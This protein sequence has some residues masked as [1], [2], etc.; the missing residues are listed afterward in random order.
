MY[1]IYSVVIPSIMKSPEGLVA[2]LV[3]LEESSCENGVNERE[4]KLIII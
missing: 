2:I 3:S 1:I 4:K